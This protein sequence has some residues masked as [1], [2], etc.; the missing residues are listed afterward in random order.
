VIDLI[1]FVGFLTVAGAYIS[2]QWAR[3][4]SGRSGCCG[5]RG[6]PRGGARPAATKRNNSI[7]FLAKC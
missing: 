4:A 5:G 6:G 1:G 2:L 3:A 7:R